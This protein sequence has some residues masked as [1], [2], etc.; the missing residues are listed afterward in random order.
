VAAISVGWGGHPGT[1]GETIMFTAKAPQRFSC[2]LGA[3]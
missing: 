3:K 2:S 1:E